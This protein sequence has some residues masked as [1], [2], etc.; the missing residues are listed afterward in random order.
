MKAERHMPVVGSN[1]ISSRQAIDM[2]PGPMAFNEHLHL[3]PELASRESD[4]FET[5]AQAACGVHTWLRVGTLRLS[6][7]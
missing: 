5:D 4:H 6:R 1:I 2:Y 7:V 3:Y